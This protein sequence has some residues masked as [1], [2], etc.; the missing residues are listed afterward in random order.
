MLRQNNDLKQRLLNSLDPAG[1]SAE[2][3]QLQ[4]GHATGGVLTLLTGCAHAHFGAALLTGACWLRG[5]SC[6]IIVGSARSIWTDVR[7]ALAENAPAK[8]FKIDRAGFVRVKVTEDLV[9]FR[10]LK[11]QA[12]SLEHALE[13]R[14]V[15]LWGEACSTRWGSRKAGTCGN[16]AVL[17]RKHARWGGSKHRSVAGRVKFVK[18]LAEICRTQFA[19]QQQLTEPNFYLPRTFQGPSF[20][21]GVANNRDRHRGEEQP[22][23][24]CRAHNQ[25]ATNA[26]S[27]SDVAV[28]PKR[29]DQP[30]NAPQRLKSVGKP[31][32]MRPIRSAVLES[33]NESKVALKNPHCTSE[34]QNRKEHRDHGDQQRPESPSQRH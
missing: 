16:L 4:I 2:L 25:P 19:V 15:K 20:D 17:H 23:N 27:A 29:H 24:E 8:L 3:L 13:L 32:I 22:R 7:D 9:R 12:E 34:Q 28:E 21:K 18:D 33:L 1:H 31:F 6:R 26:S 11:K 30:E 10:G 5:G 14:E